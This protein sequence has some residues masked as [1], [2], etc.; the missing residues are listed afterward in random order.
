MVSFHGHEIG[1]MA[2]GL[3]GNGTKIY[4]VGH[5]LIKSHAKAY[6]VYK[7]EFNTTQKG[8]A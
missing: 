7:N 8:K 3:K 2:P 4:V 6:H 5:N 1:V